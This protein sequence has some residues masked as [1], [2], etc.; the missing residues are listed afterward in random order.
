MNF[1]VTD[2]RLCFRLAD[3]LFSHAAAHLLKKDIINGIPEWT[4]LKTKIF[5]FTLH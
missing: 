2:L 3:C 5:S 4:K 1:T